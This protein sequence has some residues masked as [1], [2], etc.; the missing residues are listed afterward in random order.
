MLRPSCT[1]QFLHNDPIMFANVTTN[2]SDNSPD[3]SSAI[4]PSRIYA[5][6][7][8]KRCVVFSTLSPRQNR[9]SSCFTR[10]KTH[11]AAHANSI[12]KRE[13]PVS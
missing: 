7:R 9:P 4:V 6:A 12:L 13:E 1:W 8:N 11:A 5:Q 2:N 10:P 3:G